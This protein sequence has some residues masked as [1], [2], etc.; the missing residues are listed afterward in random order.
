VGG[1]WSSLTRTHAHTGRRRRRDDDQLPNESLT[2]EQ[3][4]RVKVRLEKISAEC[5][6]YLL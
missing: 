2:T 1:K 3:K 6:T 5:R 4:T